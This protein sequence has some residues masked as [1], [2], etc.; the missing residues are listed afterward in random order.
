MADKVTL[1]LS[2]DTLQRA[3]AEAEREGM[4]LS[5]WMDRA[6]RRAVLREAA[7]RNQ[8]WLNE[9]PDVRQEIDE[10]R[11]FATRNR[12]HWNTDGTNAA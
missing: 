8:E 6:A 9:N 10:W 11:M 1:S 2:T 12:P 3:R 5:A 4:T 7:R